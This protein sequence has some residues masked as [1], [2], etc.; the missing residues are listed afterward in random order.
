M[1]CMDSPRESVNELERK[2]KDRACRGW[3]RD[4]VVKFSMLCFGGLVQLPSV[5]LHD[6]LA[7]MLWQWP[8][9][10]AEEEWHRF[11]LRANLPQAKKPN[12]NKTKARALENIRISKGFERED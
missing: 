7:A 4:L 6:L 11:Q 9:Y 3:H 5:D 1:D 2:G 8:T 12:Q 10:K